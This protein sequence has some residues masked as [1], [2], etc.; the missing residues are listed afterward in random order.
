M[1]Y[2][3]IIVKIHF[4]FKVKIHYIRCPQIFEKYNSHPKTR[5]KEECHEKKIDTD[6]SF[7]LGST[8]QKF[9]RSGNLAHVI[10]AV[11]PYSIL[12]SRLSVL[13]VHLLI[14]IPYI[15]QRN[16]GNHKKYCQLTAH[17]EI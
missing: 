2:R 13:T 3:Y 4:K 8:G 15:F 6:D 10:Y 11:L 17:L 14:I 7:M 16:M 12:C 1:E 5:A 9:S